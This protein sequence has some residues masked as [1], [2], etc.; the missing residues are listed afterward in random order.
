MFDFFNHKKLKECTV[1]INRATAK[2]KEDEIVMGHMKSTINRL[3]DQLGTKN[4]MP[5]IV[6]GL[7]KIATDTRCLPRSL[8]RPWGLI[9]THLKEVVQVNEMTAMYDGSELA[10][11]ITWANPT[12]VP[13]TSSQVYQCKEWQ[14]VM[15]L[16]K[17]IKRRKK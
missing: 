1:I 8:R 12:Y 7:P 16:R 14:N 11:M 3:C 4:R 5:K 6:Q 10:K 13:A 2:I 9:N 17:E 15:S